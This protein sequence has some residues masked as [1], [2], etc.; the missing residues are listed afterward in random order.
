MGRVQSSNAHTHFQASNQTTPLSVPSSTGSSPASTKLSSADSPGNSRRSL[1]I[2]QPGSRGG[3]VGI[4]LSILQEMAAPQLVDSTELVSQS[5]LMNSEVLQMRLDKLMENQI[6]SSPE[7]LFEQ[8]Q[9][10]EA[11]TKLIETQS[12]QQQQQVEL[13]ELGGNMSPVD[14]SE[15]L[16]SFQL[17]EVQTG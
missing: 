4:K 15:E 16:F 14:T 9:K 13:T 17:E 8:L 6:Q 5:L 2:S 10:H 7:N 3:S 12:H 11:E 1:Q